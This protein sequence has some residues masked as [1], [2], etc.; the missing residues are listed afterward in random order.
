MRGGGIKICGFRLQYKAI[1]IKTIWSRNKNRNIHQCCRIEILE[2]NPSTYSQS[3]TGVPVMVQWLTNL[4]RNHEVVDSIPGLAQWVK[5]P[6]L[7]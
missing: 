7:P 3:M 1:V 4:N 6:V 5:D 2:L